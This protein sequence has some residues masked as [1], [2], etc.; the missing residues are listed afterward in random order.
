MF[1]EHVLSRKEEKIILKD[2]NG[3]I[4][5]AQ[6]EICTVPHDVIH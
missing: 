5:I 6:L 4:F 1:T 3:L 2:V